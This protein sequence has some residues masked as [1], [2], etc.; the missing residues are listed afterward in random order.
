ATFVGA[1]CLALWR[2][3][4][5]V[6]KGAREILV[7]VRAAL[8][9]LALTAA[10]GVALAGALGHGHGLPGLI[11]WHAL[12]GLAGW[13]G[14]LLV[15][16]SFQLIPIFQ[17]TEIYPKPLTRWLPLAI[18]GLLLAW[19][20]LDAT[21]DLPALM[22]ETAEL[23]LLAAYVVYALA[24][25]HLL[26]TR[27]RPQPEPTTWFWHLA[28]L[29]ILVCAPLWIWLTS[30]TGMRAPLTLGISIIVGALWSAVN[31]MLYKI[32][33]FLLWKHAQDRMVIP[34]H[35]P[36]QAR[37]Y[38]KVMPKMAAY[39]PERRALGQ[40]VVHTLSVVAWLAAALDV[41]GAAWGA[42]GLLTLSAAWLAINIG[43]AV[44]TYRRT[45]RAMAGLFSRDSAPGQPHPAP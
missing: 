26:Y 4:R 30:G 43:R 36:A 33:P 8:G 38:L 21:P 34:D 12:W 9:G 37:A 22:R 35:D 3:R 39:M 10:L 40:F 15:G 44:L 18:P 42:G 11:D 7:P 17:V 32:V 24:T 5:Q 29:C 14:L 13:A 23:F 20:A 2:H 16:M 6:Y 1:A 45:L 41:P 28:V 31:G 25:W 27:K 19:T